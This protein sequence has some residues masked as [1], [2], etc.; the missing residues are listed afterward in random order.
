MVAGGQAFSELVHT[1]SHL[2]HYYRDF[3]ETQG[4]CPKLEGCPEVLVNVSC[5]ESN[6]IDLCTRSLS[7]VEAQNAQ[8]LSI[9]FWALAI[10][11]VL[12]LTLLVVLCGVALLII[13]NRDT[14][15]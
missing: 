13:R 6:H 4:T 8:Y 3:V 5:P 7:V 11:I 2:S 9:I 12:S 14:P 1:M 15:A 10:I